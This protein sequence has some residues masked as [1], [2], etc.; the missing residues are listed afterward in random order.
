MTG[1]DFSVWLTAPWEGW[2]KCSKCGLTTPGPILRNQTGG[3]PEDEIQPT[4][5]E[6]QVESVQDD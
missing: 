5:E 1:H 4:C 3:Y 6:L 2:V